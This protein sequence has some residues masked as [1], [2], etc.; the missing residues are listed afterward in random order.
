MKAKLIIVLILF[1]YSELRADAPSPSTWDDM[2]A[3]SDAIILADIKKDRI[4]T[5]GDY[6]VTIENF[7]VLKGNVEERNIRLL[8]FDSRRYSFYPTDTLKANSTYYL[9]LKKRSN[10][11]YKDLPVYSLWREELGKFEVKDGMVKYNINSSWQSK[12]NYWHPQA[13]FEMLLEDGLN[14][15]K[16]I[17]YC[18]RKL[19]QSGKEE[20][21]SEQKNHYLTTMRLLGNTHYDVILNELSYDTNAITRSIVA[22]TVGNIDDSQVT[23]ILVRLVNDSNQNVRTSAIQ[24]FPMQSKNKNVL[25]AALLQKLAVTEINKNQQYEYY[26]IP[27]EQELIVSTLGKLKYTPAIT[28]LKKLLSAKMDSYDFQEVS[29]SLDS[30]GDRTYTT[31]INEQLYNGNDKLIFPICRAICKNQF[32]ECRKPLEKYILNRPKNQR[33]NNAHV[34]SYTHGIGCFNDEETKQFLFERVDYIVSVDDSSKVNYKIENL[35]KIILTF[36]HWK[37]EDAR[38]YVYKAMNFCLGVNEGFAREPQLFYT[39]KHLEDSLNN[40]IN[41]L[42][43]NESTYSVEVKTLLYNYKKS[44]ETLVALGLKF[45]PK[46]EDSIQKR[47]FGNLSK[48][49]LFFLN[50]IRQR[51]SDSFNIPL[52]NISLRSSIAW[53]FNI[54]E[55]LQIV[56]TGEKWDFF[57]LNSL[58]HDLENYF[59]ANP[60]SDDLK[61]LKGITTDFSFSEYYRDLSPL[62][63][64]IDKLE[65]E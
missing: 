14:K 13:E 65:A 5:R 34:Y 56:P 15:E 55:R 22:K 59:L 47:P 58:F 64:T 51:V 19:K 24:Q 18:F 40:K 23:E 54:D 7:R 9:F 1:S 11:I 6:K 8:N 44:F 62:E 29:N 43:K 2:L 10:K 20:L 21:K 32:R 28:N 36:T 16:N 25:G 35:G 63:Y 57:Y 4:L 3:K 61:I 45:V 49:D 60:N 50:D 26:R 17:K 37:W 12:L 39:K 41:L 27:F 52:Q 30:L 38:P 46:T 48:K 33:N 53:D 42:F 31:F